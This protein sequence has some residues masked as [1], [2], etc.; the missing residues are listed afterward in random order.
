MKTLHPLSVTRISLFPCKWMSR[1]LTVQTAA[2]GLAVAASLAVFWPSG[3]AVS[4]DPA[5]KAAL[6]A[7]DSIAAGTFVDMGGVVHR[8]ADATGAKATV[9]FF[10]LT[11][12][13]ISNA[14]SPE[15]NAIASAYRMRGVRC[16]VVQVDADITPAEARRHAKEFGLT[17]PVILDPDH[18]LVRFTRATVAPSAAILLPGPTVAYCGRIDNRYADFGKRRATTTHHDL[19][20]ALDAVLAGRPV[21]EPRTQAIGCYITGPH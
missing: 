5:G 18:R 1:R 11:D 15:I 4:N 12:C 3:C 7:A 6:E 14:Y 10:L 16:Y 21:T 20:D 17:S 8:P 19:R 2:R 9:L 13:P